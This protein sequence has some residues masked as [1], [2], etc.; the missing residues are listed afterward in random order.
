MISPMR[1]SGDYTGPPRTPL[2]PKVGWPECTWELAKI[3]VLS[4]ATSNPSSYH[5]RVWKDSITQGKADPDREEV[6]TIWSQAGGGFYQQAHLRMAGGP[7]AGVSTVSRPTP[8]AHTPYALPALLLTFVSRTS[9]G[10]PH[11][12]SSS[13]GEKG[14]PLPPVLRVRRGKKT[15]GKSYTFC[16]A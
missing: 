1:A 12:P 11:S 4:T 7:P 6:G 13:R 10:A 14:G 3:S 2:P 5:F 15:N 8:T 16:F 9:W